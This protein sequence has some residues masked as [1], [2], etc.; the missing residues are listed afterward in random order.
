MKIQDNSFIPSSRTTV[1]LDIKPASAGMS[2]DSCG[3]SNSDKRNTLY[4]IQ[5]QNGGKTWS[6]QENAESA[7][8]TTRPRGRHGWRWEDSLPGGLAALAV[9]TRHES[10]RPSNRSMCLLPRWWVN[11]HTVA[12]LPA[13]SD[14]W[15]QLWKIWR[16]GETILTFTAGILTNYRLKKQIYGLK[17]ADLA[18]Q[19]QGKWLTHRSQQFPHLSYTK[20]DNFRG[21]NGVDGRATVHRQTPGGSKKSSLLHDRPDWCWGS[22]STAGT[23][24]L[25]RR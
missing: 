16:N 1:S 2:R 4:N 24:A 12:T 6:L 10:A 19:H 23:R 18:T 17:M 3:V 9:T 20:H 13:P 5:R 15:P 14:L 7:D 8:P 22:T 11:R 21:R 25:W